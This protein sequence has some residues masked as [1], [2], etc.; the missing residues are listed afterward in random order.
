MAVR[1]SVIRHDQLPLTLIGTVAREC[2]GTQNDVVHIARNCIESGHDRCLEFAGVI[3]RITASARML[4]E[5]YTHIVGTSRLQASTRYINMASFE[6][7]IPDSISS[8]DSAL[9]KY[10]RNM[11][12]VGQLYQD[13]VELDIPREDIANILPIGYMSTMVLKIN[14]RALIHMFH[15]RTCSRA[16]WEFRE[17]MDE[18]YSVLSTLDNEWAEVADKCFQTKCDHIG[19]CI[20]KKSCGKCPSKAEVFGE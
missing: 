3:L 12:A 9:Y 14:I 10:Q 19:Y 13:L 20:E 4:R 2:Y 17:F 6:Y 1:V 18:L 15:L 16:Y 7:V 5:L 11:E 8:D